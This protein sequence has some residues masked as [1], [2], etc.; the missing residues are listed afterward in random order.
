MWAARDEFDFQNNERP[1]SLRMAPDTEFPFV[2]RTARPVMAANALQQWRA[3]TATHRP[4]H[5]DWQPSYARGAP[6]GYS[7]PFTYGLFGSPPAS[8]GSKFLYGLAGAWV[9]FMGYQAQ[10][11]GLKGQGAAMMLV[12]A[13][14]ALNALRS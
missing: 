3:S 9:A 5:R 6:R 11:S 10:K 13:G 14:V 2:E 4:L 1:E 7:A 12:G 8:G